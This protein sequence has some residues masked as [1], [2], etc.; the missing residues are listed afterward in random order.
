MKKD[1][2]LNIKVSQVSDIRRS[3][4]NGRQ[5]SMCNLKNNTIEQWLKTI[6]V[7]NGMIFIPVTKLTQIENRLV[8]DITVESENHSFIAGNNFLSSNCAQAKQAMGVYVTNY[9]ERMDKTA[10]VL[11]YPG[12]PLVDTRVMNMI[13]LNEIPSGCNITVAIMTHTGYNQEDSLLVNKASIERGLF[14]ITLYHTEK[15]EDKQKVNGD[16]EIR[17]KPDF[18]KTK[19]KKMGNYDKV[20]SKG[21]MPENSLVENRD[22]IIAKVTPIKENRNDHTKV[23]KYEDQSKMYRTN[24]ESYIDKNYIDRNGEG[25]SFAK[26]RVRAMRRPVIGDKFSSRH[27][28]KGTVGNIIPEEDMPFTKDGIRPDIII[29][30]HAIPSRMTIGQL[31]ETLLGKVLVQLGLFG[32]GTSFGDLGVEHISKK[33]LSLGYEAHGNEL[34]YSG[35]TGEQIESSIFMGPVF[36]QR[37]KHMVNDKAHS[38]SIGPMVNLTR[39]PAEGRSRDGGLRFGEMERDCMVSHGASRFTRGRMY[40][41]SD[42][43]QAHVC[44]CCGLIAAY[45]DKLHIHYCRTCDNRTDFA[46]VE[47]PYAF[48]L[49]TQ[50]LMTMNVV[51]RYITNSA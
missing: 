4:Q 24:E 3:Y 10:Y 37:L 6:Q 30:P 38:R 8:S 14:Q 9:H 43:Y 18:T 29:N 45:N 7:I 22:V 25:Y 28:Q 19:G 1:N 16:E 35:L 27:G 31:K 13:K 40:D 32:D 36:Y 20:N 44:K 46:Y 12:R 39:Q 49:I 41:A 21:V 2:L 15:D 23:I 11:N 33:L 17:C 26:V 5:I 51:P 47:I 50:E 34:L 42:K 48:K